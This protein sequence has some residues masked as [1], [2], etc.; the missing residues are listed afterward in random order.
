MM[1]RMQWLCLA[2]VMPGL[3]VAQFTTGPSAATPWTESPFKLNAKKRVK[4]DF[5]SASPDAIIQFY[6]DVSGITIVKDPALT[7]QLALSSA[8]PVSL[9]DAF[10]ILST[11]L[12]LKGFNLE[13]QGDLLVIR[14]QKANATPGGGGG[15]PFS[16]TDTGAGDFGNDRNTL[17]VYLIKYASASALSRVLNDVYQQQQNGG[18]N[19]FG[20]GGGGG[21]QF[22]RGP[23]GGPGGQNNRFGG[24]GFQNFFGRQQQQPNVRA[25][26]DDY[27]NSVI[28]NAPDRDQTQVALLIGDLDKPSDLPQHSK[29]YHLIYA[30]AADTASVVQNVLTAN[31]PRGKGG[32]TTS[33]TSG[34]QAFFSAI[35]GQ[36]PGTGQ[37]AVDARTN[38][39]IVT[40]TDDDILIVDQVIHD[41]DHVTPVETSTF[42]LPLNNARADAVASVMQAA[43]GTR[44][45]VSTT[46]IANM[47]GTGSIS[48][49]KPTTIT[50][51]NSTTSSSGGLGGEIPPTQGDAT[52]AYAPS[53]S[54]VEQS[55]AMTAKMRAD[56]QTD[57]TIPMQ[58]ANGNAGELLTSIGVVQGFG[59]GGGQ[60][61]GGG[62]GAGQGF[63]GGG[64]SSAGSTASQILNSIGTNGQQINVRDLTNQVTV[65]PDINTNSLI[66]V[67]SPQYADIVKK[68]LEQLDRVP[69]QVVID[70]EIVEAELD[71][72]ESFGVDWSFLHSLA[73]PLG[74]N[75]AT[76]TVGQ[77]FGVQAATTGATASLPGFTY[78]IAGKNLTAY[79][80]AIQG[81]TK[82]QVLSSPQLFTS[83]N[84]Q[85]QINV[86]QAIPYVTSTQVDTNG[87]YNYNYSFLNVG[88][89]LTILPRITSSGK[90]TL[91]V[92]Q[93]AN[94]LQGY[95]SFN[96]PIVNQR[97]ANTTVS[98]QDGNTVVL[99][100]IIRKTL[101]STVNKVPLLG[102][103]PILGAIFR[104]TSK[105][106]DRTEL[107]IFLT[108]HVVRS[109]TDEKKVTDDAKSRVTPDI[110]GIPDHP[111]TPTPPPAKTNGGTGH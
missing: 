20:G 50:N 10:Q 97:Q 104:S 46:S 85:A 67:A 28:V 37:V 63:G 35:R 33:Q 19:P 31:V 99:G 77:N 43:F 51:Q 11:T 52:F 21:F 100:G 92:T 108:P 2:A 105:S 71:K 24:N 23:G 18:G 65:I 76:G 30:N 107:M 25:S 16:G 78:Q 49:A 103:I 47:I 106:Q 4:L 73:G 59:G 90:V 42:V 94:D 41:L 44:A 1:R 38:A 29:V 64:Q 75:S 102:D 60:R 66:V 12:S 110:T 81:N 83:N 101:N 32:A 98:V 93:T 6:E 91:D 54:T 34:P 62:G 109:D 80:S 9:N 86:S 3:A 56:G 96:A 87:N 55:A 79:L 14:Q 82:F 84:V 68:V 27:S 39:L 95:T 72:S 45:G 26:A 89:I 17:K 15:F 40:A 111:G 69:D 13:K 22:N 70:T 48:G 5:H 88:I 61:P 8:R 58:D 57:L 7:G 36:T 53:Q 74:D